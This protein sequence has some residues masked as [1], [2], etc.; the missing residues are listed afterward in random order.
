M[1]HFSTVFLDL[2]DSV[3]DDKNAEETS[4]HNSENND[5][6]DEL[7][8]EWEEVY[9]ELSLLLKCKESSTN[10]IKQAHID[11]DE[12]QGTQDI[13]DICATIDLT[14]SPTKATATADVDEDSKSVTGNRQ[15]DELDV[16]VTWSEE[17]QLEAQQQLKQLKIQRLFTRLQHIYSTLM[18]LAPSNT[19]SQLKSKFLSLQKS[20]I[21]LQSQIDILQSEKN[22]LQSELN[23][24][25]QKVFDHDVETERERRK[26]QDANEKYV[27]LMDVHDS[28]RVR[29][30]K[31][32]ND[33]NR[34]NSQ[35]RKDY[36]QL[37]N[38]SGLADMQEMEEITE[39]YSKMSQR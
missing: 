8:S 22:T 11:R 31:Q 4:A 25:K 17:R 24:A 3:S 37:K 33:L 23:R 30:E 16:E 18:D 5:A 35:L 6:V 36:A 32:L 10:R 12:P 7:K 19:R 39:K 2:D 14:Q 9:Q 13:Q 21:S 38:V 15:Q 27:H 1:K 26:R 34:A 20:N 29:V 28:Y